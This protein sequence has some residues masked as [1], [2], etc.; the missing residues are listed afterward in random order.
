[1]IKR[2]EITLKY[3]EKE[4]FDRNR[5]DFN[6]YDNVTVNVKNSDN[7]HL[8]FQFYKRT[9]PFEFTVRNPEEE[10]DETIQTTKTTYVIMAGELA[11]SFKEGDEYEAK[12]FFEEMIVNVL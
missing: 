10:I 1:M 4:L 2:L 9:E 5:I 11:F 12:R 7:S 3:K 8:T 6:S